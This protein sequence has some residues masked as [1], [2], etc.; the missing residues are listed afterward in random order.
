MDPGSGP[1]QSGS[2]VHVPHYCAVLPLKQL[3]YFSNQS[4]WSEDVDWPTNNFTCPMHDPKFQKIYI[5]IWI[6]LT[7]ESGDTRSAFPGQQQKLRPVSRLDKICPLQLATAHS[8]ADHSVQLNVLSEPSNV[9]ACSLYSRCC[10][11]GHCSST[12]KVSSKMCFSIF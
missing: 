3:I 6:F 9:W 10:V 12:A 11:Y 8:T 1:G 4:S 5:E 7:S 2:Q